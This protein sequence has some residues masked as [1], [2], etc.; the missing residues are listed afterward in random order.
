MNRSIAQIAAPVDPSHQNYA[1]AGIGQPQFAAMVC[2]A[3]FAKKVEW[4][5]LHVCIV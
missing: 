3:Q 1:L 4:Y 2:A 5:G